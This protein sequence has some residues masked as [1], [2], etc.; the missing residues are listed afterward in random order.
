MSKVYIYIFNL[1]FIPNFRSPSHL[2][3]VIRCDA[4]RCL[5]AGERRPRPVSL[6]TRVYSSIACGV[7]GVYKSG[8]KTNR[9]QRR[10]LENLWKRKLI[11]FLR[12]HSQY[13]KPTKKAKYSKYIVCAPHQSTDCY[14]KPCNEH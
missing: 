8:G 14:R 13:R 2:S 4:T 9:E 11:C 10:K 12:T 7:W 1:A 6:V 5:A 3:N